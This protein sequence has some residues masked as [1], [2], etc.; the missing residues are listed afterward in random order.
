M[1]AELERGLELAVFLRDRL[2]F[3]DPLQHQL[4]FAFQL[5][6]LVRGIP[7]VAGAGEDPA[8]GCGHCP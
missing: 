5:R 7:I 8:D 6:I 2:R 3:Y 4:A 1:L